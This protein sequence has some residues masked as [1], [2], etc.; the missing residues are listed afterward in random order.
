MVAHKCNKSSWGQEDVA[1]DDPLK[2]AIRGLWYN[3]TVPK[4]N[5]KVV[6]VQMTLIFF[7]DRSQHPYGIPRPFLDPAADV[8]GF[9]NIHC[10]VQGLCVPAGA[11]VAV[12]HSALLRGA[13]HHW[14]AAGDGRCLHKPGVR[15][16]A[17]VIPLQGTNCV[18][19]CYLA[20]RAG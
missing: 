3:G 10:E 18:N 4:P 12:I 9:V 5:I 13:I 20:Q 8:V 6:F 17:F 16:L 7:T 14:G 15:D 19:H 2:E 11:M 1:P